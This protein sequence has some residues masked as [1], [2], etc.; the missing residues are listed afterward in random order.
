VGVIHWRAATADDLEAI[1]SVEQESFAFPWPL[2]AFRQELQLSFATLLLA[3][4]ARDQRVLGF[5]D[6]WVRGDELHLLVLAV[7][8]THR[9]QGIGR[10]LILRAEAAAAEGK[11]HY[12][13]LE[14]RRGN[15]AALAFYR[16]LGYAHVGVKRGYYSD[17]GEDALVLMKFLRDEPER[18][19]HAETG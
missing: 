14:V 9:R 17:N 12:V 8:R 18:P 7:G 4:R 11:A 2:S 13:L 5:V 6:Y 1:V 3:E 19:T 16:T 15:D 10:A